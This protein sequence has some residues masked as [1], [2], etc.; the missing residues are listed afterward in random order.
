MKKLPP[1]RL[2]PLPEDAPARMA[3]VGET[4]FGEAYKHKLARALGMGRT[5]FW[6][7]MNGRGK[8]ADLDGDLIE[9]LNAEADAATQRGI[10]IG[11]LRRRFLRERE[12]ND[13][14]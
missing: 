8:R 4:V 13:A 12:R 3:L 5:K 9:V 7:I 6:Q 2:Q 14:V 11:A 1:S 10:A